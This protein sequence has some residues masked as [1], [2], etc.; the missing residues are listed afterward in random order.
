MTR[1]NAHRNAGLPPVHLV[2][3]VPKRSKSDPE[4]DD[5]FTGLVVNGFSLYRRPRTTAAHAGLSAL[6]AR[7]RRSRVAFVVANA[8]RPDPIPATPASTDSPDT[9]AR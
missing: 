7:G 8:S 1:S 9:Q 2:T 3:A 6:A 5:G 4:S